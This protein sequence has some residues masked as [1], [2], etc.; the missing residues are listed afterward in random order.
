MA[1][2]EMLTYILYAILVVVLGI[3]GW[4]IAKQMKYDNVYL[5]AGV[6]ALVGVGI[7]FGIHS[8]NQSSIAVY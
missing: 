8:Y 7:A 2:S 6:G 5:G 1:D 3:A 4:F